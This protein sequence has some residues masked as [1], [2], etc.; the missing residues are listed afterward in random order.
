MKVSID[1]FV[2]TKY[3]GSTVKDTIEIE[4][5]DDATPSEIEREKEQAAKE[6]MFDNIDWSWVDSKK[7]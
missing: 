2:S 1:V 5:D 7:K 3:L 6:W 4:V